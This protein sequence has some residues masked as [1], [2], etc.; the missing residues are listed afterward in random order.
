MTSRDLPSADDD[1]GLSGEA[2][3]QRFRRQVEYAEGF[4]LGFVFVRS[5][6]VSATLRHRVERLLRMRVGRLTTLTPSSPAQLVASLEMLFA[7]TISAGDFLW[8]EAIYSDSADAEEKPWQS[9]WTTFALRLNEHRDSLRQHIQG[10]LVIASVPEIKGLVRDAAPDLWSIRSLVVEPGVMALVPSGLEVSRETHRSTS[11]SEA[12]SEDDARFATMEAERIFASQRDWRAAVRAFLRASQRWFAVHEFERARELGLRAVEIVNRSGD[13]RPLLAK[14]TAMLASAEASLDDPASSEHIEQAIRLAE[15]EGGA[16][17]ISW[18]ALATSLAVQR[19]ELEEANRWATQRVIQAR[20]LA[21]GV[22]DAVELTSALNDLGEMRYQ[23][24]DMTGAEEAYAESLALCRRLLAVHGDSPQALRELSI[25]LDNV[26]KVR[27]ARG[28]LAGA[29]EAY[30]EALALCRRLLAAHGDSPQALLDLSISLNN[31][32]KVRGARGDLAGAEEAYA[33]SLAI[34]RRLLAAHG[35]S[36]QALRD[37]SVSLDNVGKVRGARG[38]LAG[39]EEAYVESLDIRRRLL[40]AQGDSPQALRDL[41]ISLNNVAKV[42]DA[43]GDLA[44][45]SRG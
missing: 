5:P 19:M 21:H 45:A 18:L 3:W 12:G 8:L 1:L 23:L 33:E 34:R 42:R 22:L 30:A 44:G 37:L 40:A 15:Q 17:E 38:D 11:Y 28:D 41:S 10:G 25:S 24:H 16:P 13:D 4:W 31:V 9:A 29:E 27:D 2:E 20:R 35:D 7:P 36:P 39:A 43:R 26:G 6:R 14:A 32:G